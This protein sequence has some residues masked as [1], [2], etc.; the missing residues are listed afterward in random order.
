MRDRDRGLDGDRAADVVALHEVDPE[1]AQEVLGLLVLDEL[2]DG[3]LV[4]T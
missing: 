1:L 4:Q 2:G 3:P